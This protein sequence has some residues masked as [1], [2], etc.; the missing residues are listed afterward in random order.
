M[1]KDGIRKFSAIVF[2]LLGGVLVLSF[3][4]SGVAAEV[5]A[6]VI[7]LEAKLF[8]P[9]L[10]V[11]EVDRLLAQLEDPKT[12]ETAKKTLLEKG[13]GHHERIIRFARKSLDIEARQTCTDVIEA[14]DV[15]YRTTP[16]GKQLGTLY[17]KQAKTLLPRYWARFRKDPCDLRA[18]AM[19]VSADPEPVYTWLEK[20]GDRYDPVR[21]LLLRFRE[22]PTDRF[23]STHLGDQTAASVGRSVRDVFP[24]Q[25]GADGGYH[26]IVGN[27]GLKYFSLTPENLNTGIFDKGLFLLKIESVAFHARHVFLYRDYDSPSNVKGISVG[28]YRFSPT[29]PYRPQGYDPNRYDRTIIMT[30]GDR[31]LAPLPLL[32]GNPPT[33]SWREIPYLPRIYRSTEKENLP[34]PDQLPPENLPIG[35]TPSAD[36]PA[37]K[38][39]LDPTAPTVVILSPRIESHSGKP[40]RLAAE[41]LCDRIEQEITAAGLAR[42]VNRT[43]LS[44]ILQEHRTA[45]LNNQKIADGK[46]VSY[47]AMLRVSIGDPHLFAITHFD[48]SKNRPDPQVDAAPGPKITVSLIDLN[49]GNELGSRRFRCPMTEADLKPLV[50]LCRTS[51]TKVGQ[52]DKDKLK[53]RTLWRRDADAPTRLMTR[54]VQLTQAFRESI[55]RSKKMTL[56]KHFEANSAEEESLLLLM[57]LSRLTGGRQFSPQA[58]ATI[59][60]KLSERDAEGKTFEET[61]I[62]IAFR[63][64]KETGYRGDWVKSR[65]TV[66]QFHTLM[67]ESWKK[68][69]KKLE[70]VEP[71]SVADIIDEIPLRRKQARAELAAVKDLLKYGYV[72]EDECHFW[73]KCLSHIQTALK[74]DPTYAEAAVKEIYVLQR[75]DRFMSDPKVLPHITDI[76]DY[77]MKKSLD[78]LDRFPDKPKLRAEAV[79]FA[80]SSL[81]TPEA[82]PFFWI[83]KTLRF[84]CF[85]DDQYL[86]TPAVRRMFANNQRVLD[87][88]LTLGKEMKFQHVVKM[89]ILAYRSKK[90][91]GISPDERQAWLEKILQK[92]TQELRRRNS[93]KWG[94][95]YEWGE[96]FRLHLYAAQLM[97]ED[98]NEARAKQILDRAIA[99][100]IP[101]SVCKWDEV[102]TQGRW[103]MIRFDDLEQ[104]KK[105]EAWRKNSAASEM[106]IMTLRWPTVD[107]FEDKEYTKHGDRMSGYLVTTPGLDRSTPIQHS[108]KDGA[109][110]TVPVSLAPLIQVGDRLYVT[111]KRGREITWWD[112]T[113]KER[114][115][116]PQ[117]VAYIDLDKQGRPVGR[118]TGGVS[119]RERK[120]PRWSGLHIIAEPSG[121]FQIVDCTYIDGKLILGTF[122]SG[123]QIFDTR[124]E[125]WSK[126]STQEGLPESKVV[127]VWPLDKQR[128][129]VIQKG[130]VETNRGER[131]VATCSEVDLATRKVTLL[132]K[133]DPYY[134]R[135]KFFWSEEGKLVAWNAKGKVIDPLSGARNVRPW[136]ARDSHG[137]GGPDYE[138]FINR[139]IS[140]G[141]RVYC[142]AEA[143]LYE[144]DTDG[145]ILRSWW[146]GRYLG[147]QGFK[148][149]TIPPNCPLNL[150]M[151]KLIGKMGRA[152]SIL[153]FVGDN[154]LVAYDTKNDTWYGPLLLHKHQLPCC[155]IKYAYA[156]P[157]NLWLS[158]DYP[159]GQG[160]ERVAIEDLLTRARQVGRALTGKQYLAKR[161]AVIDALEPLDQAK[162][163]FMIRNFK[164][165]KS[166]LEKILAADPNHAEALLLMG[167]LHNSSCLNE[168][169]EA[170]TYFR[171]LADLKDRP[172]ARLTGLYHQCETLRRQ[173]R[174]KE[175]RTLIQQITQ[176][177][178]RLNTHL[179]N[180]LDALQI[181]AKRK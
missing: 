40:Y 72:G 103:A 108:E 92:L 34:T 179:Q 141:D 161:Q 35:L 27:T 142:V 120:P 128:L 26:R 3:V 43:E 118:Q 57:G 133:Q 121:A 126:I 145:K 67:R 11:D 143:G 149:L 6:E 173:K 84:E 155:G 109:R 176:E 45:K 104:F 9:V 78:F 87:H 98:G 30:R 131:G 125:K 160:L 76:H 79:S 36:L 159:S 154:K 10:P 123:L 5:P 114:E 136:R 12:R 100:P 134:L 181:Q 1:Q 151:T 140:V 8:D 94:Y 138:R 53:V 172:Q 38:K 91:M 21:Y 153:T 19:L 37:P 105:Y 96:W 158:V 41:G 4:S 31:F 180:D 95:Q 44:R 74:L 85:G 119:D 73:L 177:F 23:V 124:T 16:L 49:T 48:L 169:E 113:D 46:I 56:V 75:L 115:H 93:R 13:Q 175:T 122:S 116:Y 174:W 99:Q 47:D 39:P 130:Y 7:Q 55:E 62:E 20:N 129:L 32:R 162:V 111:T 150:S 165:S 101:P 132:Y 171:R 89:T 167:H 77:T 102:F 86:V 178:P 97:L 170:M 42:V 147:V 14:L 64:R 24:I 127:N 59:E 17:Q 82:G 152:G 25:H 83:D 157:E 137:W 18:V 166:L 60:L 144:C 90:L 63:V 15:S 50:E 135:P 164:K 58:D 71:D 54:G 80:M 2:L 117:G 69:A 107:P 61:P 88:A 22:D 51:L 33:T 148:G 28:P 146:P 139:A 168:P 68:L 81:Y 70:A 163:Y 106:N 29:T 52:I 110:G 66:S 112:F 65:A 156:T